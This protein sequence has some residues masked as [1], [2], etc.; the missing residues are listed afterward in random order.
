[1][2]EHHW[3][4]LTY[5]VPSKP[6]AKRVAIWRKLK[7]FGAVYIQKGVCLVP[8]ME[9]HK[10]HF[11][12]LEKEITDMGGEAFLMETVGFDQKEE[13]HIIERFNEDRNAE[14]QEFLGRC[15][16]FFEEIRT[17]TEKRHF[18]YAEVQENENKE[19][20]LLRGTAFIRC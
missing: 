4:L 12:M 3:L 14:Y 11:K 13:D 16:D 2:K 20:G 9:E 17:E 19:I 15:E 1:M 6:S 8:K 18:V 5:K 7:G 10:R